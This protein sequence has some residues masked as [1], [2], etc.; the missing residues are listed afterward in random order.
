MDTAGQEMYNSLPQIYFKKADHFVLVFDPSEHRNKIKTQLEYWINSI[1]DN[2]K[3]AEKI[4]IIANDKRNSQNAENVNGTKEVVDQ[5]ITDFKNNR[6]Q[7]LQYNFY[8]LKGLMNDKKTLEDLK[9]RDI[10]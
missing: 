8:S 7:P 4:T 6:D 9:V 5:I 3:I 10:K 1:N 2:N